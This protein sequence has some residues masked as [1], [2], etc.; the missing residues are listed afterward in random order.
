MYSFRYFAPKVYKYTYI[1][2]IVN[3]MISFFDKLR[4]VLQHTQLLN[5]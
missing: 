1:Y 5:Q 3:I 2:I 4:K